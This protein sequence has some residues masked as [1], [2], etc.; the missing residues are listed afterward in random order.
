MYA[1]H[2]KHYRRAKYIIHNKFVMANKSDNAED[3][4]GGQKTR[5]G[6]KYYSNAR[7][8]V[9]RT[10]SSYSS[11]SGVDHH[12]LRALVAA[13]KSP[14]TATASVQIF[15]L[16]SATW[17]LQKKR[18]AIVTSLKRK[19]RNRDLRITYKD[20]VFKFIL[21]Y[22]VTDCIAIKV[23]FINSKY[24]KNWNSMVS[25]LFF[26]LLDLSPSWCF[27]LHISGDILLYV[28]K[29]YFQTTPF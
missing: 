6:S 9:V 12:T 13:L 4:A 21:Q 2:T 16:D 8:D 26:V 7:K 27:L 10:S 20:L 19:W 18:N 3:K 23:K 5:R 15:F 17:P 22:G 11:P 1:L 24:T 25:G 28:R 29:K 14:S